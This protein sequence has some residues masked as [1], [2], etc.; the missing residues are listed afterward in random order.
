MLKFLTSKFRNQS[1]NEVRPYEPQGFLRH[2]SD[3][4]GM[5][6]S[7]D[8]DE[9]LRN[10]NLEGSVS[11][12]NNIVEAE[13]SN[14][15]PLVLNFKE[16]PSLDQENLPPP[17]QTEGKKIAGIDGSTGFSPIDIP[18][19]TED[20]KNLL[21]EK[22][23]WS[24]VSNKRFLHQLGSGNDSSSDDEIKELFSTKTSSGILSSSPPGK[25]TV[26]SK[27]SAF[28]AQVRPTDGHSR[29]KH[30]V[31]I[32]DE[33]PS[34]NFEKMQQKTLL[35]KYPYGVSRPR[36]IRIRN[37]S[38]SNMKHG[39]SYDQAML[40]FKPIAMNPSFNLAPVEE[41]GIVF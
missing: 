10:L 35:K 33:R 3:M 37:M 30:R 9:E 2:E 11:L 6:R 19:T 32:C 28:C 15:K 4:E 16:C 20:C 29:R 36:A 7:E 27:H 38:Q 13:E 21:A 14:S 24:Q 22:R 25:V 39:F 41:P 31:I 17:L 5:E 8:E 12:N 23:K 26:L 18:H 1:L 34:L 40:V